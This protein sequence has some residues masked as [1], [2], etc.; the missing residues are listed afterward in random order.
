MKPRTLKQEKV[1]VMAARWEPTGIHCGA[2]EQLAKVYSRKVTSAHAR[3]L[4]SLVR[5]FAIE[6]KWYSTNERWMQTC[7]HV[8][9]LSY[10]NLIEEKPKDLTDEKQQAG[11]KTS[12]FWRPTSEGIAYVHMRIRLPRYAMV[13]N[14]QVLEF[15]G[16]QVSISDSLGDRFD[17]EELMNQ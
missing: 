14:A 9:A 17:Y 11:G 7:K 6:A 3:V 10:W 13:Y 4:I 5:R 16:E 2:C 1:W 8:A 12:G 15:Q